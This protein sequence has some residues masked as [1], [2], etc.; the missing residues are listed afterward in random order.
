MKL[1]SDSRDYT[2]LPGY[3]AA[4]GMN[5]EV[6]GDGQ[7]KLTLALAFCNHRD[8]FSRRTARQ[9]LDGR[10]NHRL[11]GN[12]TRL[13]FETIYNGDKPRNDVFFAV[14]DAIRERL[15]DGDEAFDREHL[16]IVGAVIAVSSVSTPQALVTM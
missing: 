15:D 2:Y 6:I 3:R 5:T 8:Q 4:V 10:I 13:T 16:D 11:N 9:I 12:K 1:Q 14:V 7:C